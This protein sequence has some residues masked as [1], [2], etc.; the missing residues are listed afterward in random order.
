APRI[1]HLSEIAVEQRELGQRET[2]PGVSE[3]LLG[4]MRLTQSF[5]RVPARKRELRRQTMRRRT[6]RRELEGTTQALAGGGEI[7]CPK[8]RLREIPMSHPIVRTELDEAAGRSLR[9]VITSFVCGKVRG[10]VTKAAKL[11]RSIKSSA[12]RAPSPMQ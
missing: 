8:P 3:Q 4:Q 11:G 7:A 2:C 1:V 6:C 12:R 5:S 9:F 10:P